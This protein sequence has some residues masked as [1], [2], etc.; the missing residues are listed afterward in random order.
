MDSGSLTLSAGVSGP[1]ALTKNGTGPLIVKNVRTAGLS[2]NIGSVQV[3]QSSPGLRPNITGRN[4]R[5]LLPVV[6]R[7]SS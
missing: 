1:F 7:P 4:F 2:I 5:M 3:S 6:S